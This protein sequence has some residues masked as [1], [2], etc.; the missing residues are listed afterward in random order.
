MEAAFRRRVLAWGA[1]H[2]TL[3]RQHRALLSEE[4]P[5]ET[6]GAAPSP[7]FIRKRRHWAKPVKEETGG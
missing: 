6:S 7:H 1:V 5:E 3:I 4:E 2:L